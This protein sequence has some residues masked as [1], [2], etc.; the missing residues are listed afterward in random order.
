MAIDLKY[1]IMLRRYAELARATYLT[2]FDMLEKNM[3]VGGEATGRAV[4]LSV[5]GWG[6]EQMRLVDSPFSFLHF[7]NRLTDPRE[8]PR[9]QGREQPPEHVLS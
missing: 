6:E 9:V 3:E 4:E 5:A 2:A 7:A 8:A 1:Y